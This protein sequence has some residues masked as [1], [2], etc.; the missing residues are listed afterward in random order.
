VDCEAEYKAMRKAEKAEKDTT[1]TAF[2]GVVGTLGVG[3]TAAQAGGGAFVTCTAGETLTA[4]LATPACVAAVAGAGLAW[5]GAVAAYMVTEMAFEADDAAEQALEDA[6]E[7]CQECI[8][9]VEAGPDPIEESDLE[10]PPDGDIDDGEDMSIGKPDL[11]DES[12]FG[13]LMDDFE[14]AVWADGD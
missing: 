1:N 5:A 8:E 7:A 11:G 6:I 12:D 3:Y 9:G 4:G 14:D 13:D 10:D 2:A